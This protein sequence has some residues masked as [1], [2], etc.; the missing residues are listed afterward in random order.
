MPS[1]I[2]GF[3]SKYDSYIHLCDPVHL[4]S[5]E[6]RGMLKK[7]ILLIGG[8]GSVSQMGDQERQ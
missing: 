1:S 5:V 4:F 3:S 7:C 6:I 2:M 8:E